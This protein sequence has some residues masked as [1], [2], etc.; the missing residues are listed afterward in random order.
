MARR[1]VTTKKKCKILQKV[2]RKRRRKLQTF[3]YEMKEGEHSKKYLKYSKQIVSVFLLKIK[4][5]NM[6]NM[7]R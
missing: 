3:P 6:M 7:A 1:T 5:K 2:Q 4:L